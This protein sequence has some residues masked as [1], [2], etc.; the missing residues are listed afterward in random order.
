[1][2]DDRG[3]CQEDRDADETVEGEANQT[4]GLLSRRMHVPKSIER[5]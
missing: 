5:G 3:A 2:M 1:M 4:Q